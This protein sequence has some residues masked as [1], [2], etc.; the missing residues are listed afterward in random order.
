[1]AVWFFEASS[2]A[3]WIFLT[4]VKNYAHTKVLYWW[5]IFCP[6]LSFANCSLPQILSHGF[7]DG[8]RRQKKGQRPLTLPSWATGLLGG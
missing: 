5:M 6:S 7:D 1:L 4:L 3:S 8:H 2:R